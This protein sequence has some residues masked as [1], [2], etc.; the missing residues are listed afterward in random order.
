MQKNLINKSIIVIGLCLLFVIGLSMVSSLVQERKSYQEAVI[1]DIKRAHVGEQVLMTPFLVLGHAS[2]QG[3]AL[4][5]MPI[6]A[7]QA[8]TTGKVQ[9]RDGTYQR[10]IYRAIDYQASLATKAQYQLPML[11]AANAPAAMSSEA[12]TAP[13][14][15]AAYLPNAKPAATPPSLH[16]VM[17]VSDLRGVSQ[18]QVAVNGKTYQASF[19]HDDFGGLLSRLQAGTYVVVALD[20]LLKTDEM[21][22]L[23]ELTL[24]VYTDLAVAGIGSLAA[25]PMGQKVT[26]DLNGDWATLK[27]FGDAL[28]LTK[29]FTDSG[30]RASWSLPFLAENNVAAA[31]C[32][33]EC[34]HSFAH[35]GVDFVDDANG[36]VRIDRAIKYAL[37]ILLVSFGTFFLFETI[38][39]LK[40]HPVQYALVASALLVFYVLLLSLSEYS[41]F[42][43]AYVVASTACVGLIAWYAGFMLH[44]RVRGVLFA[45]LLALLYAL[46]YVILSASEF[47]LLLGAIFSFLLI[48]VAMF[49]TRH[50]D[51]YRLDDGLSAA[52]LDER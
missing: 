21:G 16:L 4:N 9:V 1:D 2:V 52:A 38:K 12:I 5:F 11:P 44:S 29:Q 50:I 18:S 34:V 25:V 51:W 32:V 10:G 7:S 19:G 24:D 45:L 39:G 33:G 28:P 43:Q 42:W 30:F 13:A 17:P 26:M 35:F 49:V 6:F 36:Y 27:F 47:N 22:A 8:E 37:L 40:I 3:G 31:Q 41:L 20:H 15:M 23:S 46:F 14:G 48:F